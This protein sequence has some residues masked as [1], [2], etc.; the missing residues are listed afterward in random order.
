MKTSAIQ[1][2]LLLHLG[3]SLAAQTQREGVLQDQN[4]VGG[5]SSQDFGGPVVGVSYDAPPPATFDKN[6][7][8]Y[9]PP[10]QQ[11]ATYQSYQPN[12]VDTGYI[13]QPVS[14][15]KFEDSLLST[16]WL[17]KGLE[18]FGFAI[19]VALSVISLLVLLDVS[20][21]FEFSLFKV[22]DV[23]ENLSR[24][25]ANV[26]FDQL[27]NTVELAIAKYHELFPSE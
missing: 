22:R 26:D 18:A 5:I 7:Y 25:M 12:Y 9:R 1:I 2:L 20:G 23:Q 16:D 15:A 14:V 3:L 17:K 11:Y 24:A 6:Q 8:D 27:A 10:Q 13:A 19:P 4:I 21:V